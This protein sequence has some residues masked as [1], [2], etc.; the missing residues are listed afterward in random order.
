[1]SHS[2]ILQEYLVSIGYKVNDKLAKSLEA[3]LG[4]T[5]KAVM[6][7]G[8]AAAS[9]VAAVAAAEV[10]FAYSMRKM[11]FESDLAKSS[12]KNLEA[13]GFAGE[14]IG[15]GGDVMQK[16]V[17]DLAQTI[18]LNPGMQSF[19]EQMGVKVTGRD[20]S[21]VMVDTVKAIN[22]LSHGKEYVGAQIA[23]QFGLDPDTYHQ[24]LIHM[25]EFEKAKRDT[26]AMYKD[27]GFDPDSAKNK[28]ALKEFSQT[29]DQIQQ[30]FKLLGEAFLAFAN[31]PFKEFSKTIKEEFKDLIDMFGNKKTSGDVIRNTEERLKGAVGIKQGSWID[32]G[33]GMS[34]VAGLASLLDK[35]SDLAT[36]HPNKTYS[37]ELTRQGER[38]VE[39]QAR[40]RAPDQVYDAMIKSGATEEQAADARD[41][42]RQA[43]A[44]SAP[45]PLVNTQATLGATSG[46]S[47]NVTQN[48]EFHVHESGNPRKTVEQVSSRVNDGMK[49]EIQSATRNFGSGQKVGQ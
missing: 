6:G 10:A 4:K 2:E 1:M 18:R 47:M 27:L 9:M 20:M 42:V 32:K 5:G 41:K 28:A 21:D 35:T 14:Q 26:L 33:L 36:Y 34:P 15:V 29:M 17:H 39:T 25:G 49:R 24:M 37:A 44:N 12:V 16:A 13:M 22:K 40:T 7:V 3:N 43:T 48:N 46:T 45:H 38:N 19:I 8:A 30:E 11:Y 23:E 31:G